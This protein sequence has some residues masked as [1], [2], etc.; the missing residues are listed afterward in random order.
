M[1]PRDAA[2]DNNRFFFEIGQYA[3][4]VFFRRKPEIRRT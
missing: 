1:F 2:D 3:G 4:S